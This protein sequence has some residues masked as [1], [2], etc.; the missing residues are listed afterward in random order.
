MHTV[1]FMLP[2]SQHPS[3][4]ATLLCAFAYAA[5]PFLLLTTESVALLL[6]LPNSTPCQP[7]QPE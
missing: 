2:R 4:N 1:C 6:L 7:Y 5:Y 3:P